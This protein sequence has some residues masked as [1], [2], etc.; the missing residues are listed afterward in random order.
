M[1]LHDVILPYWAEG[2]TGIC[3]AKMRKFLEENYEKLN[4]WTFNLD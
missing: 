1:E 2:N 4:K 3:V